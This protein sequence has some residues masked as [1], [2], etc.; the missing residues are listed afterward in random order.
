VPFLRFLYFFAQGD[1]DGHIQSLIAA[2]ALLFLGGQLLVVGL[3]AKAVSWN[4]QLLEDVLYRL[5]D[6]ATPEEDDLS[7]RVI[8]TEIKSGNKAA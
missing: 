5:K 3:L 1:G 4:R 6:E 2:A 7:L 8:Q